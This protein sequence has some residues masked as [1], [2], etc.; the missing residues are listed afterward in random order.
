VAP[1][2]SRSQRLIRITPETDAS[3][4]AVAGA[5]WAVGNAAAVRS[6]PE[7]QAIEVALAAGATVAFGAEGPS[8]RKG[9]ANT[10]SENHGH[11]A[12][13]SVYGAQSRAG[14]RRRHGVGA[15]VNSTAHDTDLFMA[16]FGLRLRGRPNGFGPPSAS[17]VV[18]QT[19]SQSAK[20]QKFPREHP[21][22]SM[23]TAGLPRA[24]EHAVS[25]QFSSV[26]RPSP[27]LEVTHAG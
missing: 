5:G 18:A 16:S 3:R 15:S 2:A 4:T 20:H 6:P 12:G 27:R 14:S 7:T 26:R 8:T 17:R 11:T 19:A 25:L 1:A 10:A 9:G 13:A 24:V 21:V 23:Q 22:K